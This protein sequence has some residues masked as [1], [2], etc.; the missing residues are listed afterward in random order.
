[1]VYLYSFVKINKQKVI[2]YLFESTQLRK[3]DCR[4]RY[5][6]IVLILEIVGH[7]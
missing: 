3:R 4:M 2:Y 1:M 5:T 6:N 7:H